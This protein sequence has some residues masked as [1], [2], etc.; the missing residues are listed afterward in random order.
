MS[1]TKK[2]LILDNRQLGLVMKPA[3][4]YLTRVTV[5]PTHEIKK[6]PETSMYE[7]PNGQR[8]HLVV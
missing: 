8:G 1:K 6:A 4:S 3:T 2:T 7:F 5:T